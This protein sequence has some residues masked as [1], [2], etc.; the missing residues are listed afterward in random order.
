MS[1]DTDDDDIDTA[2]HDA[3]QH[4]ATAR[5]RYLPE[6]ASLD[7]GQMGSLVDAHPEV[8]T[9][10]ED[11]SVELALEAN[12]AP[13]ICT[14]LAHRSDAAKD[15]NLVGK[16][17][18]ETELA[19]TS[20]SFGNRTLTGGSDI[21]AELSDQPVTA[22][23]PAAA[24][25]QET[26]GRTTD[27]TEMLSKPEIKTELTNTSIPFEDKHIVG[28]YAIDAVLF[29][30]PVTANVV[31]AADIQEADRRIGDT[32]ADSHR[33]SEEQFATQASSNGRAR[34]TDPETSKVVSHKRAS[35]I[36]LALLDTA[37]QKRWRYDSYTF[38]PSSC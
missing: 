2:I 4:R 32:V 6:L 35:S 16:S 26:D 30:Q 10:R 8:Q 33:A 31:A 13:E 23:V 5:P 19:D 37:A 20:V 14:E 17:Q 34:T 15:T 18:V 27:T 11:E 24:E 7:A 3:I 38:G 12:D 36:T 25:L 22:N 21:D 29:D 28:D 9:K 1:Y